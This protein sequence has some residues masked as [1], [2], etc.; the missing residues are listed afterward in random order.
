MVAG[1]GEAKHSEGDCERDTRLGSLDG[2]QD[3]G[4]GF[5][6]WHPLGVEAEAKQS[7][8][9]EEETHN[10]DQELNA[11]LELQD[12]CA[13]CLLVLGEE[14]GGDHRSRPAA[15]PARGCGAGYPQL[16]EE[17]R[18]TLLANEVTDAVIVRSAAGTSGHGARVPSHQLRCKPESV[19]RRS[20]EISTMSRL[21]HLRQG[22]CRMSWLAARQP[23]S[24]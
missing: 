15:Y 12:S 10:A 22:R 20:P 9:R 4:L 1:S 14:L 24:F 23:C 8:Q 3:G 16:G 2:D 21:S 18:I 13:E 19:G 17:C 11:A 6:R 5:P 7:N